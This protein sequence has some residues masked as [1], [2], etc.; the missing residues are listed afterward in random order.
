MKI[1]HLWLNT[2]AIECIKHVKFIYYLIEKN[3]S[4][5]NQKK[6]DDCLKRKYAGIKFI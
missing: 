3:K 4:R 1:F 2:K 5:I 6:A